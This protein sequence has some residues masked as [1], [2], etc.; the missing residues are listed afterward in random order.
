MR[1]A[2]LA[3][4][5]VWPLGA[6]ATELDARLESNLLPPG[7]VAVC[8][9]RGLAPQGLVLAGLH[10][11]AGFYF[12]PA[13]QCLVALLAVPLDTRPGPRSLTLAWPGHSQ[14]L[15]LN[16]GP[17]P[18]PRRRIRVEGLQRRLEHAETR[19][20]AGLMKE[21]FDSDLDSPPLW[22]GRM[23][24]PITFTPTVT[25]PYGAARVYNR[26]EA[27]WRHQGVDLRAP[28]G[29]TILAAA[30]GVVLLAR[31]HLALSGNTV[32][33]DHGYGLVSAYFHLS[34]LAV[35]PGQKVAKGQVLGLS[36]HSGLSAGPHLH[37]EL[38]L[39]G[40]S[41]SPTPWMQGQSAD[42]PAAYPN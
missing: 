7:S 23:A 14:A 37:F 33:L 2:V 42:P 24:W 20:E 13:D 17:D 16:V 31:H 3:L 15:A 28:D 26:G 8:R 39:R 29:S 6:R 11:E 32:L 4:C 21:A 18:Y 5:L 34:R 22:H 19:G 10:Q 40:Y 41:V 1:A 9:V 30:D 25:S 38:R 12:S 35:S 27:G 36:G